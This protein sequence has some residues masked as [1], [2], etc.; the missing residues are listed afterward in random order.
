MAKGDSNIILVVILGI[1]IT[2][3]AILAVRSFPES[4][5]KILSGSNEENIHSEQQFAVLVDKLKI[6]EDGKV[7]SVLYGIGKDYSLIAF[8][9][10]KDKIGREDCK[11]TLV[12]GKSFN[13]KEEIFKPKW[14]E[15]SGKSC[16]CLC[17]GEID[18]NACADNEN[19]LCYGFKF[20]IKDVGNSCG[21]FLASGYE[22]GNFYFKR[23][24]GTVYL[25][26]VQLS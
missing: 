24:N 20:G 10:G 5:F 15:C 12:G 11:E 7:Y 1:I 22:F 18:G 3:V 8:P 19:A 9:E 23:D 25:S 21:Y 6:A 16:L 2:I 13:L 4:L 14:A 26:R 17:K